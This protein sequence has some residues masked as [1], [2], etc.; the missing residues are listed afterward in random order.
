MDCGS[1][2]SRLDRGAVKRFR[3]WQGG[4]QVRLRRGRESPA[5]SLDL[6]LALSTDDKALTLG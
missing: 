1:Q 3:S 4:E 5:W 6:T 2:Q